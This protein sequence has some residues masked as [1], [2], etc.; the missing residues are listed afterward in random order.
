M[1]S[2]YVIGFYRNEIASGQGL[3]LSDVSAK[4]FT[5]T[6]LVKAEYGNVLIYSIHGFKTDDKFKEKY[7]KYDEYDF[8]KKSIKPILD[9]EIKLRVVGEIEESEIPK[10]SVID[11]KI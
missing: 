6:D 11:L 10:E 2:F 4:L 3:R 1:S 8:I 7:G 5:I 9:K